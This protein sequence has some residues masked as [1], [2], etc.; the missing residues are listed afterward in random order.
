MADA[1]QDTGEIP[2]GHE[3]PG[4]DRTLPAVGS[5]ASGIEYSMLAPP[6]D[7]DWEGN[8]VLAAL[9]AAEQAIPFNNPMFSNLADLSVFHDPSRSEGSDPIH[10]PEASARTADANS[11]AGQATDTEE[12]GA[13]TRTRRKPS[14][15]PRHVRTA[16]RVR[17]SGGSMTGENMSRLSSELAYH[18]LVAARFFVGDGP[19]DLYRVKMRDGL[20]LDDG[21]HHKKGDYLSQETAM[22]FVAA[23]IDRQSAQERKAMIDEA[24]ARDAKTTFP[25]QPGSDQINN[26]SVDV[27]LQESNDPDDDGDDSSSS[28]SSNQTSNESASTLSQAGGTR[29]RSRAVRTPPKPVTLCPKTRRG[30]MRSPVDLHGASWN[31]RV[32][33]RDNHSRSPEESKPLTIPLTFFDARVSPAGV[34]LGLVTE[35]LIPFKYS[36]K[37]LYPHKQ[38][39]WSVYNEIIQDLVAH[40][41]TGPRGDHNDLMLYNFFQPELQ[42]HFISLFKSACAAAAHFPHRHD[43]NYVK[44][45]QSYNRVLFSSMN[46]IELQY[47]LYIALM[48]TRMHGSD[49]RCM[50]PMV[51]EVIEDELSRFMNRHRHYFPAQPCTAMQGT[52]TYIEHYNILTAGLFQAFSE[53]TYTISVMEWWTNAGWIALFPVGQDR[54]NCYTG[55]LSDVLQDLTTAQFDIYGIYHGWLTPGIY[56]KNFHHSHLIQAKK[57]MMVAQSKSIVH[58][59]RELPALLDRPAPPYQRHRTIKAEAPPPAEQPPARTPF[60]TYARDGQSDRTKVKLSNISIQDTP[61]IQDTSGHSDS[62]HGSDYVPTADERS[63]YTSSDLTSINAETINTIIE[64]PRFTARLTA[65]ISNLGP[66]TSTARQVAY[67]TSSQTTRPHKQGD[68]SPAPSACFSMM[69]HAKC[70]READCRYSHDPQV[71]RAARQ[72]CLHQWKTDSSSTL[73]NINVLNAHFPRESQSDDLHGYTDTARQEVFTH[74]NA[75][76]I[77]TE[78]A[79]F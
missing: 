76:A 6:L 69:V 56:G 67:P 34:K 12:R 74:L 40:W 72:A 70:S 35:R 64:D 15:N 53:I 52:M 21:T 39:T 57:A 9:V 38:L 3:I 59:A 60:K 77:R 26:S 48:P 42:D 5:H 2:A 37:H 23:V 75:L 4:V 61:H 73:S 24:A 13:V 8:A 45:Y 11:D 7:P 33:Q 14:R 29:R 51:R 62:D 10:K 68:S 41:S 44:S 25:S 16:P 54:A 32:E 50:Y 65:L 36:A 22:T 79:D 27:P 18:T 31:L 71:I 17:K 78:S 20:I 28:D 1:A 55:I 43:G 58:L 19:E 30:P 49:R 47:L 63:V 66:D 46:A